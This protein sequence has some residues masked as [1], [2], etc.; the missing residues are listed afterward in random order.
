MSLSKKF[1]VGFL[2]A[3]FTLLSLGTA[4]TAQTEYGLRGIVLEEGPPK[5]GGTVIEAMAGDPSTLNLAITTST[6][7]LMVG[8]Q[9]FNQLMKA[10]LD[11]NF[12][13]DLAVS[14]E[15]SDDY[16]TWTFHLY[17]EEDIYWHDGVKFTAGDVKFSFE[18]MYLKYHPRGQTLR[19][20]FDRVEAVD[21]HT[22]V[23]HLSTGFGPFLP[24]LAKDFFVLPK[25][26]YEGTDILENPH[27][28]KPIGTGPFVLNEWRKG[29]YLRLERNEKYFKTNRFGRLPY[30]DT[31]IFKIIPDAASRVNALKAGEVDRISYYFLPISYVPRLQKEPGIVTTDKGTAGSPV[32]MMLILNNT[33]PPLNNVLVRRAIASAVDREMI[34]EL[35][36]FG[37]GKPAIGP[38]HSSLSWA[39]NPDLSAFPNGG[40]DQANALLDEANV[41]RDKNGIRFEV[42]LVVDKGV[43]LYSKT[44]EI[45]KEQLKPLGIQVNLSTVDRGTMISRVYV[46]KNYDMHVHGLTNSVDPAVGAAR[47]YVSTNIVPRGFTNACGFSNLEVDRL[48]ER[49]A[50]TVNMETRANLY[51]RLQEILVRESPVVF[52]LEYAQYYAFRDVFKNFNEWNCDTMYQFEDVWRVD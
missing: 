39:F 29:E 12:V 47:L 49:A 3:T 27:N 8:T 4:Y 45:I 35:A 31:L 33:R 7:D 25:H 30:L 6:Y 11:F 26:I 9:I 22:V 14:W 40:I 23:F 2:C 24:M 44:A 46:D 42:D 20:A 43:E 16:L 21:D 50:N 32:I 38:I 36:D 18:E 48:F 17:D 5:F 13:P 34:N 10:D 1:L 52:L 15:H 41:S 19:E 28:L 37:L 51:Y